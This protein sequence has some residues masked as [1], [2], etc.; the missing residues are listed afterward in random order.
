MLIRQN[1][2][3]RKALLWHISKVATS[4]PTVWSISRN[5]FF[6]KSR[7]LLCRL[8][9]AEVSLLEETKTNFLNWFLPWNCNLNRK[10]TLHINLLSSTYLWS[11]RQLATNKSITICRYQTTN[12]QKV[13][14]L[15][16]VSTTGKKRIKTKFL[17]KCIRIIVTIILIQKFLSKS[18]QDL[19]TTQ[20]FS[21]DYLKYK[22]AIKAT[23][24]MPLVN[25]CQ[26]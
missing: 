25:L 12:F 21:T 4:Q 6:W 2:G 13:W 3:E 17:T 15:H 23:C 22:I 9:R 26:L 7:S 19:F 10:N 14:F 5:I 11:R 16:L 8:M 24:R 1:T 18:C 20:C